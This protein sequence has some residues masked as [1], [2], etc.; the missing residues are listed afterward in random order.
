MKMLLTLLDILATRTYEYTTIILRYYGY[1]LIIAPIGTL[2][3]I[4]ICV[5]LA[6]NYHWY[7]HLLCWTIIIGLSSHILIPWM[8]RWNRNAIAIMEGLAT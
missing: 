1:S 2:I 7:L 5:W 3:G 6:T 4:V 8:R